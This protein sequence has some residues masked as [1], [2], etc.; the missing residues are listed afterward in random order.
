MNARSLKPVRNEAFHAATIAQPCVGWIAEVDADGRVAVDFPGNSLGPIAARSIIDLTSRE[1]EENGAWPPVLLSFN[2]GDTGQ[3]IILGIVRDAN[4]VPHAEAGGRA[5][6]GV[7]DGKRLLFS[8]S[9]EIV[10]R[11]GQGSITL[12]ADGRV[13]IKGTKLLSRASETNKIKGASVD[14]N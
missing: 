5:F 9:Q 14:I 10:L 12:L 11:C 4:V 8:A 6:D 13:V 1:V 7:L 2:Q 3:P